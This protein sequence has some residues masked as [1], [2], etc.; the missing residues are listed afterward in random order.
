MLHEGPKGFKDAA[1]FLKKAKGIKT[2]IKQNAALMASAQ[3]HADDLAK[4]DK[5]GHGGSDG[6]TFQSRIETHC[7]WG[8]AIYESI[9]YGGTEPEK[10]LVDL[11]VDDGITKRSH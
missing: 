5:R 2:S 7:K 3:Q 1:S 8:G 11:L 9:A 10:W 6:S 4:S